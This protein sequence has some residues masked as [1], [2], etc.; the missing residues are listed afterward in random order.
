MFADF[1]TPPPRF[2]LFIHNVPVLLNLHIQR[3]EISGGRI[4]GWLNGWIA[5]WL[6][7]WTAG[8]LDGWTAGWLDGWIVG[9]MDGLPI[10]WML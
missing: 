9:W 4:A 10:G 3:E 2:L 8:W 1:Y 7:R 5:E 6:D